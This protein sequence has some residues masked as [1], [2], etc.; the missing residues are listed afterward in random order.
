VTQR[1]E[2]S[3]RTLLRDANAVSAERIALKHQ[4]IEKIVA[5]LE[6][7]PGRRRDVFLLFRVYGYSRQ[8]IA[9]RLGIT[10]AAV[11]KHVVRATPEHY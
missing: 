4:L 8:E 3:E 5:R 9:S 10:E 6:T 11:A 2:E 1:W 7:M